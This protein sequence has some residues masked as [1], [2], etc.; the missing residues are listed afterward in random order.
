VAV[1]ALLASITPTTSQTAQAQP[2]AAPAVAAGQVGGLLPEGRV[3]MSGIPVASR[4]LRPVLLFTLPRDCE[5]GALVHSLVGATAQYSLQLVLVVHDL[6][7][8]QVVAA[9]DA[10]LGRAHVAYDDSGF[11][12]Q[13]YGT[14]TLVF[15]HADGVVDSV[16]HSPSASVRYELP[17]S[18]LTTQRSLTT[19]RA[20]TSHRA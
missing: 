1:A 12:E 16:E 14:D 9:R 11:I 6:P 3:V 15:V 20:A 13:A 5:C 8:A 7:A 17:L 19:P 2:L 18:Q 4:D 10:G